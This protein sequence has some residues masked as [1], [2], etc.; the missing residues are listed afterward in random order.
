MALTWSLRYEY[1]L[2]HPI[3]NNNLFVLMQYPII[4]GQSFTYTLANLSQ[5]GTYFYHSHIPL[6]YGEG[7]LGPLVLHRQND[8]LKA[9]YDEEII[10]TLMDWFHDDGT[11]LG[12]TSADDNDLVIYTLFHCALHSLTFLLLQ[13]RLTNHPQVSVDKWQRAI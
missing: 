6:Q 5:Y 8:P 4:P 13:G 1:Y 9:L 12:T 7:L 11:T 2:L 10:I 3:T